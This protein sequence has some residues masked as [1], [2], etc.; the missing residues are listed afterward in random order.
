[1]TEAGYYPEAA[2][3]GARHLRSDLRAAGEAEEMEW[4]WR[5]AERFLLE[6]EAARLALYSDG[7][8][9]YPEEWRG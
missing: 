9:D 8:W 7:G 5:T 4:A 6:S 2:A 3:E 1:M